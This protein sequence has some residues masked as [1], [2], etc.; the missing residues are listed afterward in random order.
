MARDSRELRARGISAMIVKPNNPL[1][2]GLG[3]ALV[4]ERSLSWRH[5]YGL[6]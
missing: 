1:G 4:V 6:M 3:R 2:S 5:Q